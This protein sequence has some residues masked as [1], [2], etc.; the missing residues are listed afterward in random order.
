M[1][2]APRRIAEA[3]RSGGFLPGYTSK[4]RD[5]RKI[6]LSITLMGVRG[7]TA[8]AQDVISF[9]PSK[10]EHK[11]LWGGET[12]K[13]VPTLEFEP[14]TMGKESRNV[15]HYTAAVMRCYLEIRVN[16]KRTLTLQEEGFD[17]EIN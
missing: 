16:W 2:L 1:S 11:H 17:P 6:G 5:N 12:K 3:T 13:T 10:D 9:P 14:T 8:S 15:R 7:G 4:S